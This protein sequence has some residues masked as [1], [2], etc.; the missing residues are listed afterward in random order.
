M[1]YG[2]DKLVANEPKL[3]I[4]NGFSAATRRCQAPDG[5]DR[6]T[7]VCLAARTGG[8]L[9]ARVQAERDYHDGR[10]Q[11]DDSSVDAQ[12]SVYGRGHGGGWPRRCPGGAGHYEAGKATTTA[13]PARTTNRPS[14]G[15]RSA[16]NVMPPSDAAR[17]SLFGRPQRQRRNRA[18]TSSSRARGGQQPQ[19]L[20]LHGWPLVGMS[21][22]GS[23][24]S[25]PHDLACSGEVAVED[26]P[27]AACRGRDQRL[28]VARSIRRLLFMLVCGR[29]RPPTAS[30]LLPRAGQEAKS[31]EG[32][33]RERRGGRVLT[34]RAGKRS[35][36]RRRSGRILRR[37]TTGRGSRPGPRSEQDERASASTRPCNQRR[38]CA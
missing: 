33:C 5:V 22:D 20:L 11:H 21:A 3:G 34:G 29:W 4:H 8:V 25:S 14:S 35:D 1:R 6:T 9:R 38:S 36:R 28:T 12:T 13:G 19:A 23:L 15:V 26:L 7:P 2:W 18:A 27:V 30:I 24:S 16:G 32:I 10:E 31:V 37:V 17:D